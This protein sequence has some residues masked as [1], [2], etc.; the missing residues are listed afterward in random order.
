MLLIVFTNPKVP[1]NKIY[2]ISLLPV[3]SLLIPF[4]LLPELSPLEFIPFV[5]LSLSPFLALIILR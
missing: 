5:A 4:F 3:G 1:M 2:L